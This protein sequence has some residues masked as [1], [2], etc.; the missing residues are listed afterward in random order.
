M[1]DQT[2]GRFLADEI[3]VFATEFR[4]IALTSYGSLQAGGWWWLAEGD[5]VVCRLISPGRSFLR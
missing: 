2:W 5:A 4:D 1:E 3:Q